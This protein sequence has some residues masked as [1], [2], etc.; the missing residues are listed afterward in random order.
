MAGTE[1]SRPGLPDR[2]WEGECLD[3]T[4]RLIQQDTANPPGN[5]Y[6]AGE[7]LAGFL[8]S[9]GIDVEVIDPG[10]GRASVVARVSGDASGDR[11]NPGLLLSHLDVSPVQESFWKVE[12]FAAEISGDHLWGRGA[13]D[14]KSL[15]A[16]HAVALVA[17]KDS[18]LPILRDIALLSVADETRG[19]SQGIRWIEANRP[20]LLDV[21]WVLGEGSFSY[22]SLFGSNA[23]VF[24]FCP[25]EKTALW[26]TLTATGE[27]GH[28]SVPRGNTAVERLVTALQRILSRERRTHIGEVAR[29]FLATL[30]ESGRVGDLHGDDLLHIVQASPAFAAMF[31]DTVS[32]TIVRAGAE[33][34]VVPSEAYAVLDCRLLPKTDPDAFTDELRSLI[35]DLDISITETFRAVSGRSDP[36]GPVASALAKAV[37]TV[38][39]DAIVAPVVSAGYT[40][41]R[42]FRARDIPAYGCHL[43]PITLE[44][45]ATIAGHDERISV[46]SLGIA[47]RVVF[48]FLS[49]VLASGR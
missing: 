39:P 36:D 29:Q 41:L 47:A 44:E 2:D 15:V 11:G 25:E 40:D 27:G 48:E 28:S 17:L 46:A 26:L 13:I 45:R 24:T 33:T 31:T 49:G 21:A 38:E 35:A 6:R 34:S 30:A 20:E 43:A 8:D 18:G 3:L 9:A 16:A 1:D 32:A 5:E 7:V 42:M 14:L 10:D 12:P 22:P 19:G 23:P 37:V 4:R